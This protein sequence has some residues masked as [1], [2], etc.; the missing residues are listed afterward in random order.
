MTCRQLSGR[1]ESMANAFVRQLRNLRGTTRFG[2][3]A[4][5]PGND[6]KPEFAPSAETA[7]GGTGWISGVRKLVPGE[8]LAGYI[9]L[10]ALAKVAQDPARVAV[11]LAITFLAVTLITRFLGTQDPRSETPWRTTQ[12]LVVLLSGLS[13][14][15]LVYATGGQ[16][17][18][19]EAIVDQQLY[20]QIA[21]VAIGAVGPPICDW[22]TRSTPR[23]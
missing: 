20:G 2:S 13:F 21:S 6:A 11:I 10:Q 16:I 9:S 4:R 19:H 8:A 23:R 22:V 14:V 3:P 1:G 12:P 5:G 18:W 17:F 7:Q 15:S